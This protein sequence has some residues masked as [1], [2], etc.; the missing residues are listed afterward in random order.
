MLQF[1]NCKINIG[2]NILRK[3]EDGYHDL[4]TVF[5]PIPLH[6]NLE[7]K[8]LSEQDEPYRLLLSGNKIEGN[9]ESNLIVRVYNDLKQEFNLP[10]LDI[11]LYKRGRED[12]HQDLN[13][14]TPRP[15]AS[16]LLGCEKSVSVV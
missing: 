4:A 9:P 13:M 8:R 6:D 14:L 7:I 15:W 12:P 1:P 3:R 10:P 2:L 16:S 5:Y 11:H